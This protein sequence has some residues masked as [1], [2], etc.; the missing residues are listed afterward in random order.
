MH[1]HLELNSNK[2]HALSVLDLHIILSV[3]K[4]LLT[5]LLSSSIAFILL[6]IFTYVPQAAILSLLNG[7]IGAVNAALLVLSESSTII[8][9][10]AR[11]FILEGALY[12]IFDATLICEGQ[13]ALVAKGR[14]VKE[15]AKHH[16]AHKL[17]QLLE[18]PFQ[19]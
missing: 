10:I 15:G 19:K 18:K 17:G 8:G 2:N 16:G 1:P 12:D 4:T 13:E 3:K 6:A 11:P 14:E 5:S 9:M 7:P